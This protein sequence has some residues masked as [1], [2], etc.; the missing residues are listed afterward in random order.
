MASKRKSR[1]FSPK[2]SVDASISSS[3]SFRKFLFCLWPGKQE[4]G[5]S[6]VGTFRSEHFL[7][8]SFQLL[9]MFTQGILKASCMALEALKCTPPITQ[10]EPVAIRLVAWAGHTQCVQNLTVRNWAASW[11]IKLPFIKGKK[12]RKRKTSHVVHHSWQLPTYSLPAGFW[13]NTFWVASFQGDVFICFSN[14]TFGLK[15]MEPMGLCWTHTYK[16]M[17]A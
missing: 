13:L 7:A 12:K 8:C 4:S 6:I 14:L 1:G 17:K 15:K 5:S 2:K 11:K 3:F 10:S 16:S 9:T